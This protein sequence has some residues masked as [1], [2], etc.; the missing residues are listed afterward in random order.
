MVPDVLTRS[1]SRACSSAW[2]DGV[3]YANLASGEF[4]FRGLSRRTTL[5]AAHKRYPRSIITGRHVYISE[6]GS[7]DHI[8]GIDLPGSGN[9]SVRIYFEHGGSQRNE[10]PRC[11]Q[12]LAL[13]RKRYG[14]PIVVQEFDEERSRN[15]RLI[16]R[17]GE[18]SYRYSVSAWD[19]RPIGCELTHHV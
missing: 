4:C 9:P 3:G 11:E 12:V 8:Y 7:H 17:R 19:G 13:I 18:E 5:E 16:W 10:Y 2:T 14:E 1:L 15:R 6:A